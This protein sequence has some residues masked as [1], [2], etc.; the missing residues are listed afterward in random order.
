MLQAVFLVAFYG[1]F[2]CGELTSKTAN[3]DYGKGL[4]L[5]DVCIKGNSNAQ[6][7][8]ILLR[9][10]KTDPY[11]NGVVV[12]LFPLSSHMCPVK[13]VK[14]YISLRRVMGNNTQV[15]FFIMPSLLPLTRGD[16]VTICSMSYL[17]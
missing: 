9:Y 11:G 14:A 5:A 2:R 3:F 12:K 17:A 10:S 13:A 1:F 7:L 8:H 6:E 4:A 15:S 16:F